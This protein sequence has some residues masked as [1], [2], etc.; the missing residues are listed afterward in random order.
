MDRLRSLH[1]GQANVIKTLRRTITKV[2]LLQDPNSF[3]FHHAYDSC[4][5][6]KM[7]CVHSV[8]ASQTEF[9][10]CVISAEGKKAD[11][12]LSQLSS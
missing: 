2:N 9:I 5:N 4:K 3:L 10:E 1:K 8:L 6:T 7:A 12:N 11:K